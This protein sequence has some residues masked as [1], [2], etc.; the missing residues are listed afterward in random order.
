MTRDATA[1]RRG[2]RLAT[3]SRGAAREEVS[4]EALAARRD[5][6]GFMLLYQRHLSAVYRYAYARLGN[7]QDA[8]DLASLVFERAWGDLGRYRARG[9][10]RAWLFAIA[11][12]AVVDT[13]RRQRPPT[14]AVEGLTDLL[15]D[16]I[17]GP[18]P[19]ALGAE[20][21]RTLE[22]LLSTLRP[23]QRDVL[24]L[25]FFADLRYDEIAVVLGKREPAVKMVAY[26]A[27][28]ALRRR[29]DDGHSDA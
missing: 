14:V 1:L 24:S 20:E 7:R 21:R 17:P 10:F 13:R 2:P 22:R 11:H 9:T 26:R 8:E 5:V 23:E 15:V 28:E 3:A 29:Y 19:S 16:P 27:L 25:R 4:D 18:E 12:R 6:D